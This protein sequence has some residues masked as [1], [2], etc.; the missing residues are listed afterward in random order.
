M[1]TISSTGHAFT[2]ERIRIADVVEAINIWIKFDVYTAANTYW[3]IYNENDNG[4]NG[5]YS[6]RDYSIDIMA[7]DEAVDKIENIVKPSTRTSVLL[8]MKSDPEDGLIEYW[9]DDVKRHEYHGNVNNGDYFENIF[10]H[11]SDDGTLFSN[12]IISKSKLR[13]NENVKPIGFTHDWYH[14]V[15]RNVCNSVIYDFDIVLFI[16][17][18]CEILCDLLRRVTR[19]E[20][21]WYKENVIAN[22]N[23][24]EEIHT[25][26]VVTSQLYFENSLEEFNGYIINTNNLDMESKIRNDNHIEVIDPVKHVTFSEERYVFIFDNKHFQDDLPY[27]FWIDGI[28][29]IPDQHFRDGGFE[30]IYVKKDLIK[31]SGSII[32]IEKS[33]NIAYRCRFTADYINDIDINLRNES[34]I[35]NSLFVTDVSGNVIDSELYRFEVETND[36]G[37]LK[38]ENDSFISIKQDYN[39]VFFPDSSLF[40]TEVIV[41]YYEK[42]IQFSIKTS[43]L[44][45]NNL[46]QNGIIK[47]IKMKDHYIRV[48]N[49]GKLLS[50]SSY[51]ISVTN[52]VDDPWQINI[53]NITGSE[54]IVDFI[55]EGYN[56]V[57]SSDEY[58]E[59]GIVQL[60]GFINKPYSIRIYDVYVNGMRLVREQ[61]EKVSD[62]T[63]IIKIPEEIHSVYVYEKDLVKNKI[64]FLDEESESST[65][66]EK[67]Y[68]GDSDFV[69]KLKNYIRS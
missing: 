25:D 53:E 36:L 65:L 37:I 57:Y 2:G 28:R 44:N 23:M 50:P 32:E 6:H 67:I 30:F 18:I 31:D 62:F 48:Y 41:G 45:S 60:T 47:G 56:L 63:I 13:V 27:K 7:N 1:Y 10:L 68:N 39:L 15:E 35:L 54:Y 34:V 26:W 29:Y 42:P 16:K 69:E 49:D 22:L 40:G 17:N 4:V 20:S 5:I 11:A 9:Y 59:Y 58:N 33:K 55:P 46:N 14:D 66:G 38:P 19:T 61:I 64:L 12:F 8:H 21:T 51:Q 43:E 52:N 24:L 3:Q